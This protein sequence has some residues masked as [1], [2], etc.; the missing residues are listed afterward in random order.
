MSIRHAGQ[1]GCIGNETIVLIHLTSNKLFYLTIVSLL[2]EVCMAVAG[3]KKLKANISRTRILDAA[4]ALFR[5]QG[6][7]AVSLRAIA[8]AAGMQSG[9]MYYHFGSKEEIVTEVLNM[10][11]E[12]VHDQVSTTIATLPVDADAATLIRTGI[13]NHLKALFAFGA[14]TSANVRIYGQVPASARQGNLA[15]RRR[16]EGLWD[17]ILGR[18][19]ARGGVQGEID[20][21]AFRLL[22]IGSLNATLEWFDPKR[23]RVEDLAECYADILLGGVLTHG[24]GRS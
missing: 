3:G 11:I 5:D 4:A 21:A 16:Y 12:R 10:G 6:Y 23:G 18:A 7:A 17:D 20:L 24:G 2:F 19:K 13:R 9:S 14:Y 15:V 1:I 8:G 22:L